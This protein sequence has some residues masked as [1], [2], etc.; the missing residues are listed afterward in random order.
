MGDYRQLSVWKR[1]HALALEVYRTT[2]S[3]P[4]PETFGLIAQLRRASV[5]VVSNIA[6]GSARQSDR[7][8]IRFL[9]MACGSICELECQLLLS[10]HI[11]YLKPGAW[12]ILDTDCR[13]VRKMLVG[14]IR[15]LHANQGDQ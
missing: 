2:V 6:E 14:L 4:G 7:E 9:R 11:G 1:A 10:R 15:F 12:L 8:Q 5:S 3:F 13:D